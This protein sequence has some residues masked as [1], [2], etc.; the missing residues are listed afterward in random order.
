M[1][2]LVLIT[3]TLELLED[4]LT[5]NIKTE[6]IARRL[7]CSKSTLEKLFRFA[8]NMSIRDYVIR[9]RMSRAA[10][11]LAADPEEAAILDVAI[12]AM[13]HLQEHLKASG[14]SRPPSIG[15]I[16]CAMSCFRLFGWKRN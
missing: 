4:H 2:N 9:R 14:I 13:R 10:R 5:E 6:E 1:E 3:R 12:T 7:Y 11:D 15:K 16:L 8:T